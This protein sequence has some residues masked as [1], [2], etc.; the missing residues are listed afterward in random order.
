MDFDI[1]IIGSGVVGSGL[2]IK[3]SKLGYKV[4]IVDSKESLPN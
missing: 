3:V 4:A 1:L 2:A